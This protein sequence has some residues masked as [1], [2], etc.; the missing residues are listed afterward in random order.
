MKVQCHSEWFA[1]GAVMNTNAWNGARTFGALLVTSEM[2]KSAVSSNQLI[3]PWDNVPR[4]AKAQEIVGN[5]IVYAN[6]LQNY[7]L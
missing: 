1:T 2:V 4:T 6:Y 3:R 7:N 5:R